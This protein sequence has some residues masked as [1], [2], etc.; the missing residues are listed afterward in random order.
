MHTGCRACTREHEQDE[1]GGALPALSAAAHQSWCNP[2]VTPLVARPNHM[3]SA[4]GARLPASRGRSG[5]SA[6]RSGNG[7]DATV[8]RPCTSNVLASV[9]RY[10][11]SSPEASAS[12]NSARHICSWECAPK[13]ASEVGRRSTRTRAS[14]ARW[15]RYSSLHRLGARQAVSSM[16]PTSTTGRRGTIKRSKKASGDSDDACTLATSSPSAGRQPPYAAKL[17]PCGPVRHCARASALSAG[18]R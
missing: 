17:H 16:P 18:S 3:L 7:E 4:T 8:S 1:K 5:R 12:R 10:S 15:R 9:V 6:S 14:P 13:A 2:L 11:R